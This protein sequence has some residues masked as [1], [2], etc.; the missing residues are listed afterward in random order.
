MV[1]S[2]KSSVGESLNL[3]G[4]EAQPKWEIATLLSRD[5]EPMERGLPQH[6]GPS[7]TDAGQ[8]AARRKNK[9]AHQNP[10]SGDDT[11]RAL[12]SARRLLTAVS[13]PQAAEIEKVKMELLRAPL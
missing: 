13:A 3:F 1:R 10:F 5:V 2:G 4:T 6:I 11:Y 9:W 7:R 8:R 12:D